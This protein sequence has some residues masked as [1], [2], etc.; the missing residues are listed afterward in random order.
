MLKRKQR[1]RNEHGN[2]FDFLPFSFSHVT[3]LQIALTHGK[4]Y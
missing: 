4:Y 3:V 1:V 2:Q